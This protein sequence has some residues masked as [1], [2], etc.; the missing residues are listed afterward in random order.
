MKKSFFSARG[1]IAIPKTLFASLLAL[2]IL[3]TACADLLA[4]QKVGAL[5]RFR[6]SRG[7]ITVSVPPENTILEIAA[8]AGDVVRKGTPLVTFR[9]AQSH[10]AELELA[11]LEL[12]EADRMG[13]KAIGIKKQ[14]VEIARMEKEFNKGGLERLIGGGSDTYS[15][16]QKD[17]KQHLTTMAQAK[18]D[19]AV[20]EL[21]R[22]EETRE[23]NM[24]RAKLKLEAARKKGETS[25]V[26][27]PADG[28]IL[29]I[30]QNPGEGSAGG[31]VLKMADL[32]QMDVAAEVFAGDILKLTPGRKAT[33]TSNALPAPL[34]GRIVSIG[35]TV[36]AQSRNAEALIRLD[37][38]ETAAR[39]INMEVNVSI[40]LK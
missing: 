19:L 4:E 10:R 11:E 28:T 16:Q 30:L 23:F 25:S 31:P 12:K 2:G 14:E 17:E 22:L 6:P 39:L 38:P 5:G 27:A 13:A 35:R 34:T 26:A 1:G 37:S 20:D 21:R 3:L 36:S 18:W 33:I 24:N 8:R 40:E 15:A 9:S 32:R 29:E 7:V